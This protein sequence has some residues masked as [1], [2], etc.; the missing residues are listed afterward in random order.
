MHAPP[1]RLFTLAARD[2]VFTSRVRERL[3]SGA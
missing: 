2:E 3:T 1:R